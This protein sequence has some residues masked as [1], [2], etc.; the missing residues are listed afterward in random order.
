MCLPQLSRP[1]THGLVLVS[2]GLLLLG[3]AVV[4]KGVLAM[5]PQARE[6]VLQLEVRA[7]LKRDIEHEAPLLIEER[8]PEGLLYYVRMSTVIGAERNHQLQKDLEGTWVE[9]EAWKQLKKDYA[10]TRDLNR[11]RELERMVDAAEKRLEARDTVLLE[12]YNFSIKR[13]YKI[14]PQQTI[15]YLKDDTD[16]LPVH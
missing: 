11:R 3:M 9:W 13:P 1:L 4:L 15:I 16:A 10:A 5:V 14:M 6:G 7:S 12:R 2:L 8:T